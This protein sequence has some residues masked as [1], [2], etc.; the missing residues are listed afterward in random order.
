MKNVA[1]SIP[2]GVGDFICLK[3]AFDP[4]KDQFS[5]IKLTPARHIIKDF[6]RDASYNQFVDDIGR[7]FF[8]DPPYYF[9]AGQY[10]FCEFDAI[11][12][13]YG[14]TPY[15]PKLGHL[16]CA[17]TSL[18][19]DEE[20]IVITTKVRYVAKSNFQ[21]HSVEFWNT[22]QSLSSKY[23]IVVIGEREV[24]TN[25][26]YAIH[27]SQHI[28]SIYNDIINNVPNYRVVD[29]T[30]PALGISSPN[31]TQ[32]QQDCLIMKEA[33]FV[34]TFGVGGNFCLSTAVANMAIGWRTDNLNFFDLVYGKEYPDAIITKKWD[35]FLNTLRNYL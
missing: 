35:H 19:L 33:K 20:Y 7:L 5:S 14:L 3:A 22:I 11:Y 18:N 4:V 9:D 15:K 17:G 31:L 27:T 29:L 28:Y 24:E 12:S 1:I 23:K 25:D 13:N 2:L 26:E 34:I 16:L 30:I 8:S 32:L 6:G 21:C 10:P